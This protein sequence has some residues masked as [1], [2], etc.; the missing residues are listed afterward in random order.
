MLSLFLGEASIT[1]GVGK[2]QSPHSMYLKKFILT[3]FFFFS[4]IIHGATI[5]ISFGSLGGTDRIN[6]YTI[7]NKQVYVQQKTRYHLAICLLT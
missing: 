6:V 5:C 1:V 4:R 2:L 3:V 7:E